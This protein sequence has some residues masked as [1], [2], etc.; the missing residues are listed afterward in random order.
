MKNP[1]PDEIYE[2]RTQPKNHPIRGEYFR[3]QT[4]I[5]HCLPFRRLKHKTQFFFAP[6]N[7]HVC[8]RIEHVLHVATIGATI[9]KGLS[10]HG[11]ELN[12]EL[13]YAIGLGHDLGHAPFGHSGETALNKLLRDSKKFMHEINSYRVAEYLSND[14]NGLNLTYAVKD[15][16]IN[17]N[18]E[19]FEQTLKP[20]TLLH[21]LNNINTRNQ[22]ATT[23]EGCIIRF[24]DKIA[25]LGRDIEDAITTKLIQNHEIPN[26][27]ISALGDSNGTIINNFVI[28]IIE[29]S[30]NKDCIMLSDEK[31][32]LMLQLK[33]FNYQKIYNHPELVHYHN[34]VIE[35]INDIFQ[36]LHKCYTQNTNDFAAYQTSKN[37]LEKEFGDYLEKMQHFYQATNADITQIITDYISG[38]TDNY[39][40][41]CI[42]QI[43]IPQPI[44]INFM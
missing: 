4:A 33:K 42:Q 10:K 15:G 28:D 40:L 14:G 1:F 2:Q 31:Y 26:E 37:A 30:K 3:D 6:E 34:T 35:I 11:W 36:F 44:K 25:Y 19:Q 9:C 16:I 43:K 21:N 20:S 8:T 24:A 39:A 29:S 22:I 7:D 38:M 12:S 18:G 27:I 5:I 13:A 23:Y 41:W 17:H 32:Q